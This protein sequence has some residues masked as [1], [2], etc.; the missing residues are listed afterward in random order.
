MSRFNKIQLGLIVA[1]LITLLVAFI[2][3]CH[4]PSGINPSDMTLKPTEKEKVAIN[5]KNNTVAITTGKGT[6]IKH[7]V[8]NAV[9][10]ETDDGNLEVTAP[11]YGFD[12]EP[13]IAL[14]ASSGQFRVGPDVSFFYWRDFNLLAGVGFAVSRPSNVVGYLG[15]GYSLPFTWTSD[16]SVFVGVDTSRSVAV[17]LRLHF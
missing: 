14:L 17:G 7:G 5:L 16:T 4:R 6:E 13:G 2:C 10:T 8:K 12:F 3:G 1:L 11:T 15:V 9:I